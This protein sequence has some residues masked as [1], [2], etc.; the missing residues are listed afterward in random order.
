MAQ[1]FNEN[2]INYKILDG[3]YNLSKLLPDIGQKFW[4]CLNYND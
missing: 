4:Y 2:I 3:L 1:I